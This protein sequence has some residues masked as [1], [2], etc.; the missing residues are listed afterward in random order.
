MSLNKSK[1]WVGTKKEFP[2][3]RIILAI[4]TIAAVAFATDYY[5]QYGHSTGRSR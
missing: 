3:K 1:L 5:D 2:M 4:I